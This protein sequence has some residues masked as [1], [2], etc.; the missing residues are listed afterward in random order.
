MM[1]M[2]STLACTKKMELSNDS[3]SGPFPGNL[4]RSFRYLDIAY[5]NVR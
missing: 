2:N 1:H 3:L 4:G 5:N